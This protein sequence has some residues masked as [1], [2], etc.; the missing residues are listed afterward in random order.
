MTFCLPCLSFF[1]LSLIFL[2]FWRF[3]RI[4]S[5]HFVGHP[6]H[7]TIAFAI[8]M[9][10]LSTLKSKQIQLVAPGR[11]LAVLLLLH[12]TEMLSSE[13]K[14]VCFPLLFFH[15][16]L[17]IN[18]VQ[19][20]IYSSWPHSLNFRTCGFLFL[21]LVCL[22][23]FCQFTFHNISVIYPYNLQS[24]TSVLFSFI[25]FGLYKAFFL[26]LVLLKML[27]DKKKLSW[28]SRPLMVDSD[29]PCSFLISELE[30]ICV[31]FQCNSFFNQVSFCFLQVLFCKVWSFPSRQ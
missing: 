11:Q 21:K 9:S 27:L 4:S 22:F 23:K 28:V 18:L 3:F 16:C 5:P 14:F 15:E 13:I 17:T 31:S 8:C 24:I 29:F 6:A 20:K 2:L 26:H 10:S 12:W 7:K 1:A 19:P 25:F 30:I